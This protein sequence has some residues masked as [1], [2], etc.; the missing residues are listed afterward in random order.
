MQKMITSQIKFDVFISRKSADIAL[1]NE[2][3][4]YLN[5]K[6]I[7]AFESNETLPQL[8]SSD[9]RKTIDT[10]LDECK[11]M[12]VVGSS[13]SNISSLWVEAEWGFYIGEKR[14]GR[15][16]GNILTVITNNI[17]I[18]DLPASLRYYEVIYFDKK[19]FD[20]IAAYVGK[21]YEDP[22]YEI[23]KQ[24]W[25]KLKWILPALCIV[26]L[27]LIFGYAIN[28]RSKPFDATLFVKPTQEIKLN[29]SYP[30]FEGGDVSLFLDNKEEKKGF[31]SNNEIVFR[32]LPISFKEKQIMAKLIAKHWKLK[33][34]T[35]KLNT[36][37]NIEVVPDG[38]LATIYGNVKDEKGNS[39]SNCKINDGNDTTFF[40]NA[41][42]YFKVI[43]PYQMQKSVYQLDFNKAR[44]KNMTIFYYPDSGNADIVL[45]K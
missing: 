37:V 8:G 30:K 44:Y 13:I 10:T 21:E 45:K 22:K 32:Q 14:A 17:D 29:Q 4:Q 1:A 24:K 12:I 40:T 35:I 20:R 27:L 16:N 42:G 15:K 43:L 11:H 18:K 2:L 33:Y 3:Y 25:V 6:G 5:T 28:E 36:I 19:N 38:S 9:Y 39:I 7:T 31:S 41:D 23:P 26:F 34:D